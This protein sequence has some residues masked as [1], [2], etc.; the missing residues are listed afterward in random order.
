MA[1]LSTK[2]LFKKVLLK[3][4]SPKDLRRLINLSREKKK[5]K[6]PRIDVTLKL[7]SKILPGDFLHYGYFE[8]ENRSPKDISMNDM[9]QAQ[10]EYARLLISKIK[11]KDSPVRDGGAY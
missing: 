1:K 7:F 4:L 11:D 9:V 10:V 2:L 3:L 6:R 5:K 8:D